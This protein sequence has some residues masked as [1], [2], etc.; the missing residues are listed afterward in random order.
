VRKPGGRKKDAAAQPRARTELDRLRAERDQALEQQ[1]AISD[2]LSAIS[3]S[4]FDLDAVLRTIAERAIT[5]CRADT[6]AVYQVLDDHRMTLV[7]RAGPATGSLFQPG[8][9]IDRDHS[10]LAA[11]ATRT[12]RTHQVEDA[13]QHPELPKSLQRARLAVPIIRDGVATG[14]LLLGRFEPSAFTE[15]EVQLVHTFAQQAGIAIE[16]VRLFN[17]TK[18]ALERQTAVS[19]ILRVIAGSPTDVQPVLDAIAESAARFCG[20]ENVSVIL[21]REDGLLYPGASVG[22]LNASVPPF[23]LNRETVTGRSMLDGRPVHVHDLQAEGT[24]YPLGSMQ[25]RAMGHRTTLATPLTRGGSAFGAILMRRGEV[26]PFTAHQIDLVQT[27]ADQAVIAIENVRLF[28]ETKEALEQQTATSE[29]LQTISRSA[30][31]LQAVLD[32]VVERAAQLCDAQQAW[33]R[34]I[35]GDE[36]RFSAYYGA[37]PALRAMFEEVRAQGEHAAIDYAGMGGRAI[38][39]RRPIHVH[40]VTADTDLRGTSLI[41]RGGGRT[42]LAIPMLRDGEPIGAIVIARDRVTPFTEREIHLIET[43][44]DQAVIAIENVRL[45]EEIQEKGRLLEAA[46]RHKSEFLANM[47]HELRTP[48]NAI[49]GFSEVLLQGMFGELNEKQRE[50][51]QD[52]LSS[53]RHLLSL[54]NDIL[55][56]S[57]IEAGRTDLELSDFSL[58]DALANGVTMIRER[59]A[60]H[61]IDVEL[62]GEGIDRVRADERKVKQIVF[63]LLSNAIKFTRDGGSVT[64]E[65]TRD[66]SEVR[67]AVRDTG[68][69]IDEADRERIFQEFQQ[70]SRDPERSREGTGLGLTLTKRF[71][72]LHGGRIW[73]ESEPGKGSTFTFTLPQPTAG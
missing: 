15:R 36:F 21:Q 34:R 73:V 16:N 64:I 45:F 46:N 40:D 39:E 4:V 44:A 25:A 5:L 37:S 51:Q 52:V 61:G 20:A 62:K 22:T 55:D 18:E 54:I 33:L 58:R 35:E 27:F 13:E 49:I 6:C 1:T 26:R 56:L 50:Y 70:A 19:E 9:I 8:A 10:M 72:E 41:I 24:D 2:V 59:A 29:V 14:S 57:K 69:G 12:L 60:R 11:V 68:I 23:P 3:G 47:S 38:L 31:D 67:V 7:A 30:F 53:G 32:T 66:D 65:A 17:E 42:G 71:V 63:N 28:N 48:L 43:F